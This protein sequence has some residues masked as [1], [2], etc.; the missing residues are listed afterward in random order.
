MRAILVAVRYTESRAEGAQDRQAAPTVGINLLTTMT[1]C[2]GVEQVFE[3]GN[4]KS[5]ACL[6]QGRRTDR[7]LPCVIRED[8]MQMVTY[9]LN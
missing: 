5:V 8:Q 3:G 7:R 6:Y 1:S 2:N 9:R 4:T